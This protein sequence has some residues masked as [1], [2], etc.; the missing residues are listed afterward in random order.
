MIISTAPYSP[1]QLIK[2]VKS[3]LAL[4]HATDAS[5]QAQ[6]EFWQ[7]QMNPHFIFNSMNSIM[8]MCI[9]QP[10]EAYELLGSFSEYLRGHLFNLSL[11]N[12]STLEKEMDLITAYLS[13]EKARFGDHIQYTLE[14]DGDADFPILPL[15]IEPLVENSIK[16]GSKQ[17]KK[18]HVL[19]KIDQQADVL[20][21]T[22]ADNGSGMDQAMIRQILNQSA[23]SRSIGLNNL[24]SRLKYYYNTVPL[25]ESAPGQGTKI[26]FS[27]SRTHILQQEAAL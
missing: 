5:I 23:S 13:I 22:V 21:V 11:D 25:I 27:I 4:K 1:D 10:M 7:A 16:H 2:K 18:V 3:L 12:I 20:T 14:N 26:S 17:T 15:L 6:M 19:V 9:N 8:Q 24:C